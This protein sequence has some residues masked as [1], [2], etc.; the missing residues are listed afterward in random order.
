MKRPFLTRVFRIT[1]ALTAALF[2][3]FTE[4]IKAHSDQADTIDPGTGKVIIRKIHIDG[5]RRT[6]SSVI[7]REL[8]FRE[9]DT[10]LQSSF[11]S[12]LKES[13]DNV[14]N[15]RLF[16]FVTF[17]TL[18]LQEEC[19]QI[20]VNI[21]VVERWYIWPVPFIEI[22]D[23]NFN[24]WLQTMDF[25]R[26][27]YGIDLTV[28]NIRGRN[29]TLTF[30]LHFGFNRELGINYNIPF[31]NKAKTFGLSFG[32]QIDQ[33]HEVI[34]GSS[35]NKPVY[36]KDPDEIIRQNIYS[37]LE[38]RLR[39]SYY[40]YHFLRIAY[41]IYSFSDSLCSIPGYTYR[42]QPYLNFFTLTYQLKND[43]RDIAYYPMKGYYYDL[44]LVQN[45][46]VDQTVNE[47]YV[48]TNIR[49]FFQI[50]NRWYYAAGLTGK[51][52]FTG[53][54]AYFL[55]Q[56]LG[57]GRDYVRGY[58]YYVVDGIHY[59]LLKNNFKFSLIRPGVFDL[60]FIKSPK[61]NPVPYALYLNLFGDFA[62]VYNEDQIRNQVNDL[63]NRLL[64][65]YGF[66]FDFTTYYDLVARV[67]FSVTREGKAGI[68][69]HFSA[70]I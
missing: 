52:T 10:I 30:P 17:D 34:V 48:K 49:V 68:Y 39:P 46:M 32:T 1:I 31:V 3:S 65:G 13:R 60:G 59:A 24:A 58:E 23:R 7:L 53:T 25:T 12:L 47:L 21:H 8:L 45:G 4:T 19:A 44:F 66:G 64:I 28:Y 55:Q 26:L 43:H 54:P 57:Y 14:F 2:F 63:Q 15:T 29:E 51:Y 27:T 61:F 6:K 20:Q 62:Y 69:F 36:Y 41:N 22:S 5:N 9:N 16:N 18:C 40:F 70:P 11:P 56:G 67:E 37:F 42:D 38:F 35:D 50:W 33:N